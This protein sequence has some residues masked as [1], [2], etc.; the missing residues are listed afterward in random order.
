VHLKLYG[1]YDKDEVVAKPSGLSGKTPSHDA[2]ARLIA[3]ILNVDGAKTTT[4]SADHINF[5]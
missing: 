1:Q 3:S 5:K 4:L 2:S